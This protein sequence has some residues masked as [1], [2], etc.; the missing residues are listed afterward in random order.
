MDFSKQS[1]IFKLLNWYIAREAGDVRCRTA[2][3][4]EKAVGLV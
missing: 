3:L 1:N 2:A 4:A